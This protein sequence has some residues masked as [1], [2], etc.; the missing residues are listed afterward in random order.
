MEIAVMDPLPV[1]R[2]GL[3]TA[4]G[5]GRPL[6]SEEDLALWAAGTAAGILLLTV[7]DDESW[8]VLRRARSLPQVRVVAI[9]PALTITSAA[10]V[11]RAGAVHAVSRD[12]EVA[13]FRSAVD[14]AIEGVVRIPV[15]VIHAVAALPNAIGVVTPPTDEEIRWLRELATGSTV[16]AVASTVQYSERALYRR[17]KDL[18]AKL[19]VANRTQALVLAR[20][21]GW[22]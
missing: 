17:L 22:L 5:Q 8:T 13:V 3:L 15:A 12:A 18:Y 14:E 6:T 1:F 10:G 9:L 20:E 4:L 11:L 21:Q 16:T 19:G 7:E 2:H